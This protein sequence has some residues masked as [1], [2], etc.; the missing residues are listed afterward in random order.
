MNKPD[1]KSLSKYP[2]PTHEPSA[3][4][5]DEGKAVG[6]SQCMIDLTIE[7]MY[8][9][10]NEMLSIWRGDQR[11]FFGNYSDFNRTPEGI[12]TFLKSI[13]LI[14]TTKEQQIEV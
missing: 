2:R 3:E 6:Y 7:I 10:P 9:K 12:S 11:L 4:I 5:W 13:G 1:F 8:D 14:V